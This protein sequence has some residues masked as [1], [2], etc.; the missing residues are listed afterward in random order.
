ML[1]QCILSYIN[2]VLSYS[3]LIIRFSPERVLVLD[4]SDH[5]VH[6]L[7]I[8][9]GVYHAVYNVTECS[10]VHSLRQTHIVYLANVA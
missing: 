9:S 7:D 3:R 5:L 8:G 4:G 1:K 6:I 2:Q 10:R